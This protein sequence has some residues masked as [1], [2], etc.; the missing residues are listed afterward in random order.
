VEV[1]STA[2]VIH[3]AETEEELPKLS[4]LLDRVI[5]AELSQAVEP[6]L[7]S[8]QKRAA[9]S[10]D[11]RHMMDS[12][13]ALARVARYGNVRKTQTDQVM[14]VIHGLFERIVIGLPGA[15][16]S[17]DDDA[18][19]LMVGSINRVQES[20][21]LINQ[22]DLRTEWQAT[23]RHL[24]PDESIHGLIR[25]R[26]C[27]LLLEQ[28]AMDDEEL[29]RHTRLALSATDAPQAARWIEGILQ[30]SAL[31]IL[32]QDGLWRAL[33]RWLS[34]LSRETFEALLPVLRRSFSNFQAPERRA[35]AE[36][37]QALGNPGLRLRSGSAEKILD[38]ERA[39]LVLPIL[40]RIVGAGV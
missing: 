30:G 10:A 27:R 4:E 36:K 9:I 11:V 3:T 13:P 37:V 5:L 8:L 17:L 6:V 22:D 39:A 14:P 16:F 23:L 38:Q 26:G 15:C 25:G 31:L 29:Q 32:H 18:A 1:A 28:Q 33:D 24:L 20:L 7:R 2:Y 19:R 12:L 34:E 21:N 35:M 40:S